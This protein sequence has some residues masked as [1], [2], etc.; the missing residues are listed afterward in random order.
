MMRRAAFFG[1]EPAA[2]WRLSLKEWR[3]LVGGGEMSAMTGAELER[4]AQAWPDE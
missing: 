4:L 3:W 2:F 1:V